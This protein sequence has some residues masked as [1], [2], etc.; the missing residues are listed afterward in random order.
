MSECSAYR[1]EDAIQSQI[2]ETVNQVKRVIVATT[3][4]GND[5]PRCGYQLSVAIIM[6]PI[7]IGT[8]RNGVSPWYAVCCSGGVLQVELNRISGNKLSCRPW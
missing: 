4:C 6:T 1:H 2:E 7:K 8:E 3:F 5:C